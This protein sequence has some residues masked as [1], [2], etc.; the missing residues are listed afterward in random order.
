MAT[1][2]SAW[3]KIRLV[4]AK[5]IK[6]ALIW[7]AYDGINVVTRQSSTQHVLAYTYRYMTGNDL[8]GDASIGGSSSGGGSSESEQNLVEGGSEETPGGGGGG[9]ASNESY[10]LCIPSVTK[11]AGSF[12]GILQ[13]TG[14]DPLPYWYVPLKAGV[15]NLYNYLHQLGYPEPT[16]E[17][18]IAGLRVKMQPGQEVTV[19]Y[20]APGNWKLPSGE[21]EVAVSHVRHV[22]GLNSPY[23]ETT[24]VD[25]QEVYYTVSRQDVSGDA[26]IDSRKG[27]GQPNREGQFPAD[28]NAELRNINFGDWIF[29]G[30]MFV[31]NVPSSSGDR[32]GTSR[33][34]LFDPLAFSPQDQNT[35]PRMTVATVFQA[36]KTSAFSG[37]MTIG[38]FAPLTTSAQTES[39]TTWANKWDIVPRASIPTNGSYEQNKDPWRKFT[40]A[41]SDPADLLSVSMTKVFDAPHVNNGLTSYKTTW[42]TPVF[43]GL[44]YAMHDEQTLVDSN[45]SAWRYL[46]DKE[47]AVVNY[48]LLPTSFRDIAPR[49]WRFFI[50]TSF[51]TAP[52]AGPYLWGGWN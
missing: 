39:N 11:N 12:Q 45:Y 42:S 6:S 31:G 49:Y 27:Y 43:P 36:G 3:I 20:Y 19:C 23:Y 24:E 18:K 13:Q 44:C 47:F 10:Y 4:R 14:V 41:D 22:L 38:I 30:G 1:A 35:I 32:S 37:A 51:S 15:F 2:D 17:P 21:G 28:P 48:N 46:A 33:F 5:E 34:Q 8:N 25:Q 50:S 9:G 40:I 26:A 29:K 16:I 7:T 52:S